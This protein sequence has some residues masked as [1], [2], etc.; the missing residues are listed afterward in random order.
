MLLITGGKKSHTRIYGKQS[1]DE[2]TYL[3]KAKALITKIDDFRVEAIPIEE[4]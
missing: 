4:N 1:K 2:K 3:S